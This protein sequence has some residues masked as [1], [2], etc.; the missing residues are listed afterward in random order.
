[1]AQKL[2]YLIGLSL[3]LILV[4]SCAKALPT[5]P[6]IPTQMPISKQIQGAD[7]Q[8]TILVNK[9]EITDVMPSDI[10]ENLS[11]SRNPVQQ[12]P[13]PAEGKNFVCLRL[14]TTHIEN[15]HV[16][17]PLGF[18]DEY[19][20]LFDAKGNTYK[21]KFGQA[22][23]KLL[24]ADFFGKTSESM[25]E[26]VEGAQGFLVFEF[27]KNERPTK[28]EFVYSFKVTWEEKTVKRGQID[29]IL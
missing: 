22:D 27:P 5:S 11:P 18:G 25:A 16:T 14:T 3:I 13:I 4:F 12:V 20:A 6:D 26:V 10:A 1:M 15:V 24:C 7:S 28:V 9:L 17:D 21:P 23:V 29:I 19:A 2:G 8:V